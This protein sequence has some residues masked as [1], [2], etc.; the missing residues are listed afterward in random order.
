M[1][2]R[3]NNISRRSFLS[4]TAFSVGAVAFGGTLPFTQIAGAQTNTTG[5]T[6]LATTDPVDNI[7]VNKSFIDRGQLDDL[8]KC[9]ARLGVT[10]HQWIVDTIGTEYD[11]ASDGFDILAEAAESAHKHGLE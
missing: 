8:H 2:K 11:N 9:L 6:L 3:M 4:S 10:R 5:K 7:L 1:E